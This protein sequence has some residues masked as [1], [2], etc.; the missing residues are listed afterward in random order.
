MSSTKSKRRKVRPPVTA[1][2]AALEFA[3]QHLR[4]VLVLIERLA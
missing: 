3:S 1:Q 4:A 2:K